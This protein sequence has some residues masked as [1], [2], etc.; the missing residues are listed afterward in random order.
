MRQE[1]FQTFKKK[2]IWLL[3]YLRPPKKRPQIQTLREVGGFLAGGGGGGAVALGY[4]KCLQQTIQ[5]N[6]NKENHEQQHMS[7][8]KSM[9]MYKTLNYIHF[10]GLKMS[11][12]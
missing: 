7:K 11:H 1:F 6:Q 12:K 3:T 2:K 8:S 5:T 10:Y 4:S 9:Y